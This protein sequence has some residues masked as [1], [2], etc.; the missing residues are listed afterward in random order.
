MASARGCFRGLHTA[1]RIRGAELVQRRRNRADERP[2][3]GV[4]TVGKLFEVVA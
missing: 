3:V 4:E 1:R 2:L